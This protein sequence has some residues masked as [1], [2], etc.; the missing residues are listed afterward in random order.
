MK[1]KDSLLEIETEEEIY[2]LEVSNDV[3]VYKLENSQF[4][5]KKGTFSEYLGLRKKIAIM[6]EIYKGK[7]IVKLIVFSEN[8]FDGNYFVLGPRKIKLK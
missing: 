1:A 6:G 2:S 3:E 8:D 7:K 4:I 5:K